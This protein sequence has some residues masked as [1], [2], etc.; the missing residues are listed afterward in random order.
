[1]ASLCWT[2]KAKWSA[3]PVCEDVRAAIDGGADVN[4]T[5]DTG[6]TPLMLAASF[7]VDPQVVPLLLSKGASPTLC[8]AKGATAL[9]CLAQNNTSKFAAGYASAL[10]DKGADPRVLDADG[11]S[12]LALAKKK[13]NAVVLAVLEAWVP[14]P[15]S[16]EA[17]EAV[18]QL[19]WFDGWRKAVIAAV[20][21]AFDGDVTSVDLVGIVAAED[22][23]AAHLEMSTLLGALEAAYKDGTMGGGSFRQCAQVRISP[24]KVVSRLS[25]IEE[26]KAV[27]L[28]SCAPTR[29]DGVAK[30]VAKYNEKAGERIALAWPNKE[31]P[32]PYPVEVS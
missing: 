1:M 6:R 19:S 7:S 22:E 3:G 26:D 17:M 23:A 21:K 5:A 31:A 18:R 20:D 10:L 8:D 9:H 25:K 14:P 24:D 4:E 11:L 27:V 16:A 32:A 29:R 30:K 2:D 13:K 28:V 15:P 12:A